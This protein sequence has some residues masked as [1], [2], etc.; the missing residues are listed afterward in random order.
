MKKTLLAIGAIIVIGMAFST[1]AGAITVLSEDYYGGSI[2]P[3]ATSYDDVIG[4]DFA[5]DSIKYNAVAGNKI[6]VVLQGNYFG[7]DYAKGISQY[8]NIGDL[9]LNSNGWVVSNPGDHARYDIFTQSEGWNYVVSKSMGKIYE[10]NYGGITPT[11][12]EG[13]WTGYRGDQAY[14]GGY[15]TERGSA[16]WVLDPTNKTLTIT[17]DSLGMSY[18]AIGYHWTMACGNDVVEGGGKPVPEPGT[19][20]L[21]GL[22]VLGLG[23][24]RLRK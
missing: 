15:G 13:H 21:L 14:Q 3:T 11:G 10:L 19:L 1:G 23:M 20:I 6:E 12:N 9:Y 8:G 4:S 16:S 24:A 2:K 5:V 7:T 22:G 18:D 17:F